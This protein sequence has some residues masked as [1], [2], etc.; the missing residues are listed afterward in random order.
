MVAI[1]RTMQAIRLHGPGVDGLRRETIAT[2]SLQLHQHAAGA[3]KGGSGS[4]LGTD[5]DHDQALG[6]SRGGLTTKL[7]LVSDGRGRPLAM[8]VTAGQRHEKHPA[9]VVAGRHPCAQAGRVGPPTTTPAMRS[10][11]PGPFLEFPK[12]GALGQTTEGAD[13]T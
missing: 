8:L 9:S 3:R 6:R 5:A 10:L 11:Q 13:R 1:P 2:P 4:Y 12:V 7:H